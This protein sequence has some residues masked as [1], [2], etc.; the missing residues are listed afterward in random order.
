VCG[1]VSLLLCG[2]EMHTYTSL[3]SLSVSLSR[4]LSLSLYIYIYMCVCV[5]V[6]ACVCV[7]RVAQSVYR[8]SYGLDGSGSN[9]GAD[10][11]F[12]PSKTALRPTQLL[13]Q[14]VPGLSR[15]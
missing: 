2:A 1:M 11:I 14:W 8:L 15:G 9:P 3:A 7:G 10:E 4:S 6:C 12:S 13:V 5:C